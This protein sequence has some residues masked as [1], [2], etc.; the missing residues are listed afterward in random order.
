MTRKGAD[1]IYNAVE[2]MPEYPGGM[3]AFSITLKEKHTQ[4][5]WL[6]KRKKK[7]RS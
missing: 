7:E 6:K 2:T 5:N 3:K 4:P 1:R